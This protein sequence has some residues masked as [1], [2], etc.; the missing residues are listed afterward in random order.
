MPRFSLAVLIVSIIFWGCDIP[1]DEIKKLLKFCEL[2]WEEDCLNFNKKGPP[3]KT[4][5]ITQARKPIYKTSVNSYE[6]Y[7]DHLDIFNKIDDLKKADKKKA[8]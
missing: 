8:L 5:S 2:D 6:K 7:K 1:E 4:V 3:I